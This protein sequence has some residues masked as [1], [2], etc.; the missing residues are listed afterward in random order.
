MKGFTLWGGT[1]TV[2]RM[3]NDMR[4]QKDSSYNK[5][6]EDSPWNLS[7]AELVLNDINSQFW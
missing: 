7:H 6:K 5:N 1:Q 4:H 3:E 2:Q